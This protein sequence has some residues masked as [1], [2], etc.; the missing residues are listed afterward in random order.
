A[1]MRAV[2]RL[3]GRSVMVDSSKAGPRAWL[4]A[5]D[6]QVSLLHLWRDPTD[7]IASWR[8]RKFDAG[9]GRDMDRPSVR[10][11]ALDW[12]KVEQLVGRLARERRV[13][14]LDYGALCEA[15]RTRLEAALEAAGIGD[16]SG[17]PWVS[18]REVMPGPDYH[19]LNG[20]PDR[21]SRDM[22]MIRAKR[23]D[24]AAYAVHERVAIPA[25]GRTLA[26]LYP[27]AR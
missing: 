4:M 10:A 1:L 19:S 21:F 3:G 8:S 23:A 15:P 18:E 22:I 9:L 25:V 20:N 12:W 7:V 5:T 16:G 6:P 2:A 13:A 27:A 26:L 24:L 14:M 17:I 11:A